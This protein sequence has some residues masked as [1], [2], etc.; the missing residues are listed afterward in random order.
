MDAVSLLQLG[1]TFLLNAAFAWLV[2]AC[3]AR[4]WWRGAD[5]HASDNGRAGPGGGNLT[6]PG[7]D[8]STGRRALRRADLLAAALGVLA[9][10]LALLV[11]T[12]VMG[13]VGM[14]GACSMF[15]S[16]LTGTDYGRAGSVAVLAM[17]GVFLARLPRAGDGRGDLATALA[18]LVFALTRASMGHAGEDGMWTPAYAADAIHLC[19]IGLWSGAVLVSAWQLPR[20]ARSGARNGRAVDRYLESMSRAA[21]LAVIAIAVTGAYSAWL[22]VGTSEHLLHS[23][24][25]VT[26]LVKL[27]LVFI[28]L[29]L[30]GYNKF[31]G[32]P[33]ARRSREGIRLVGAVLRIESAVLLGVLLVAAFLSAQQPPT[34]I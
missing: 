27:A 12:A 2:G 1:S 3:C 33:A 17:A 14:R 10:A 5:A 26:L 23:L 20:E 24:Y 9:G 6:G 30:G 34:A 25:G 11:A 15:W 28:A 4:R 32:L 31:V 29:A 22:R 8:A 21:T 16:M 19:A 13:G 18:L 7:G